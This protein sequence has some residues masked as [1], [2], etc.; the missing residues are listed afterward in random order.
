MNFTE[1][2]ATAGRFG[3]GSAFVRGGKARHPAAVAV[4]GVNSANCRRLIERK[5]FPGRNQ[6]CV[7]LAT[8][9]GM[10]TTRS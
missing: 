7:A 5:R 2:Y 8:Q 10:P 9:W 1:L 4:E 6:G 3:Q